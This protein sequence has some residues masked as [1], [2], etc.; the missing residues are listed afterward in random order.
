M[1]NAQINH[2]VSTG[3]AVSLR[4]GIMALDW[5]WGWDW[6]ASW[7]I[8]G[9]VYRSVH[10]WCMGFKVV[11]I[12]VGGV[13]PIQSTLYCSLGF[14]KNCFSKL[15]YNK[16]FT[17]FNVCWVGRIK[18]SQFLQRCWIKKFLF[19]KSCYWVDKF[20][21]SCLPNVNLLLFTM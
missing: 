17:F 2:E 9:S 21:N 11:M 6:R 8:Y 18:L 16:Y 10:G 4:M 13:I 14:E 12:L 7:A 5:G 20:A 3:K 1:H 19:F 15:L